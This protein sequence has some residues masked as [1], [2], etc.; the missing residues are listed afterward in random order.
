MQ[1]SGDED[2]RGLIIGSKHRNASKRAGRTFSTPLSKPFLLFWDRFVLMAG[3]GLTP[4]GDAADL[5]RAGLLEFAERK[6]PGLSTPERLIREFAVREADAPGSYAISSGPG[7]LLP[8]EYLSPGRHMLVKLYDAIPVPDWRV[9]LHEILEFNER[10]RAERLALRHHVETIFLRIST[11]GDVPLNFKQ[12]FA[13]LSMAASEQMQVLQESRLRFKFVGLEAKMK[14]S[15][16]PTAAVLGSVVGAS[17]A[18]L[19]G[20]LAGAVAGLSS[21]FI[22]KIEIGTGYGVPAGAKVGKPFQYALMMKR[23][24]YGFNPRQ[25]FSNV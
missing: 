1:E 16:D 24:L 19:P 17:L 18:D 2:F 5:N 3:P 12:E 22:P 23:E 7:R 25:M 10:R 8:H 6:Y 14:W 13:S 21:N 15:F 4:G 9:P 20:A 11:N